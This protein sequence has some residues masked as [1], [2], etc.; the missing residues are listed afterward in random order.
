MLASAHPL[1]YLVP[2]WFVAEQHCFLHLIAAHD[3]VSLTVNLFLVVVHSYMLWSLGIL[4][5]AFDL[6]VVVCLFL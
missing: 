2:G 3:G 1:L 6:L 4:V 5:A